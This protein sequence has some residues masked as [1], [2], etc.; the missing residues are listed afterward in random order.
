MATYNGITFEVETGR[1]IYPE[2][3]APARDAEQPIPYSSTSKMQWMG[4]DAPRLVV[5]AYFVTQSALRAMLALQGDGVARSLVGVGGVLPETI[6]DVYLRRMTGLRR[7]GEA[8]FAELEFIW[9]AT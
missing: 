2:P 3:F 9:D 6:T 7:V 8:A 5:S 1:G 4:R